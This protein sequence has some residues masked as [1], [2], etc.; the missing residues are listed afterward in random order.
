MGGVK[1]SSPKSKILS[2]ID[3]LERRAHKKRDKEMIKQVK[4]LRNMV[5]YSEIGIS[6]DVNNEYWRSL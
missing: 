3:D 2:I 6:P 1:G 5:Y 4:R